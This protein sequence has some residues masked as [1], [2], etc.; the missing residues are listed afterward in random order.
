MG[1]LSCLRRTHTSS[2]PSPAKV[3]LL[4]LQPEEKV[5]HEVKKSFLATE[6]PETRSRG[7]LLGEWVFIPREKVFVRTG[8]MEIKSRD[9][10]LTRMVVGGHLCVGRRTEVCERERERGEDRGFDEPETW[11]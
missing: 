9:R 10:R 1:P 11:P 7:S 8:F 5:D 4:N 6:N 2:F 3:C